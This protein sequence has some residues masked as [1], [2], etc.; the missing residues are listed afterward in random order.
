[1]ASRQRSAVHYPIT[2]H[3]KIPNSPSKDLSYS[4][5]PSP[6][7][8]PSE[9]MFSTAPAVASQENLEEDSERTPLLWD[10]ESLSYRKGL[11]SYARYPQSPFNTFSIQ[12]ANTFQAIPRV[13]TFA[14]LAPPPAPPL[15]PAEYFKQKD[16]SRQ[17]AHAQFCALVGCPSSASP[18]KDF[19][20]NK[21]SLYG[22]TITQLSSQRLA[23]NFS[24]SLNNILLLS[25]VILGA[26]LTALG[27]SES[28][29]ILITVFGATNT[30]IAGVVAYLKS[31]AQPMRSRMYRDDLER[32][33]DEIENSEIMWR[34]ISDGAHG[35]ADIDTD[36]VTVRSEVARLTRLYDR[37]IRLNGMNNPDMYMA[38]SALDGSSGGA[39]RSNR[40][41]GAMVS[42]APV[43]A[44]APA[45]TQPSGG[46]G[47][48]AA[49]T[50]P[51]EDAAPALKADV[52]DKDKDIDKDKDKDK[53]KTTTEAP[54]KDSD[55]K[56]AATDGTTDDKGKAP[57][58][59]SPSPSKPEES[60]SVTDASAKAPAPDSKPESAPAPNTTPA[61]STASAPT[62]N[63][64]TFN[65]ND[66]DASP[67]M[68]SH[69]KKKSKPDG[70]GQGDAKAT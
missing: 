37:A 36:E 54:K 1:M 46:N 39:N 48:Q 19:K 25:Q 33:V 16:T 44:N 61:A 32:I 20:L 57:A 30:I 2:V 49:D 68:A 5:H 9:S 7:P 64:N 55:D 31:R 35:Y 56:K 41:G 13:D 47:G 10:P 38:G 65:D 67:A 21:K 45:A 28:S 52:K 62:I 17:N 22:R 60:K 40:I 70:T 14:S 11:S 50:Q 27:A 12:R 3:I 29:H 15:P 8:S 59:P 6:S 23:Y 51:A 42:G 58:G 69:V 34:G 53:D 66:P 63:M 24:A 4:V 18:D 43:Q 26:A